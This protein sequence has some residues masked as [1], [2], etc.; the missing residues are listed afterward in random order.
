MKLLEFK[1]ICYII[2]KS[3]E[4]KEVILKQKSDFFTDYESECSEKIF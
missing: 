1:S 3:Y 4:A 2:N